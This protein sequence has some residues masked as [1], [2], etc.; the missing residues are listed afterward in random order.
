MNPIDLEGALRSRLITSTT[1]LVQGVW[2]TQGPANIKLTKGG[3]PTI[4]F[5]LV[6]MIIDDSFSSNAAEITYQVSMMDHGDNPE[7]AVRAVYD[8]VMGD[9]S[10][11]DNAPTFGLHRW[12]ATGMGDLEDSWFTATTVRTFHDINTWHWAIEFSVHSQEK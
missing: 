6:S 7:S 5:T 3:D 1:G 10:G 11:T 2:N 12:Q 9:S 4:V 8:K